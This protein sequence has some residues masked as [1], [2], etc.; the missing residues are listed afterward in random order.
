MNVRT[1]AI[2]KRL[3]IV[4]DALELPASAIEG[5]MLDEDTLV[6]FAL[7]HGVSLDWL[8]FG[9]VRPMLRVLSPWWASLQSPAPAPRL[10]LVEQAVL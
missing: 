7:R 3:G 2:R 4:A 8:V 5:A 9:D 1:K 6:S 10:R